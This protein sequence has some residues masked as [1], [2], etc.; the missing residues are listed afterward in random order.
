[1]HTFRA[2]STPNDFAPGL[3]LKFLAPQRSPESFSSHQRHLVRQEGMEKVEILPYLGDLGVEKNCQLGK[4]ATV[5][6]TT[7][8]CALSEKK[9][10]DSVGC[11]CTRA[12]NDKCNS[13]TNH[14]Y[15]EWCSL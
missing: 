7:V 6:P 1:M 14:C 10:P 4:F 3:V 8:L 5:I 9:T 13:F 15:L 12:K 11:P 2:I